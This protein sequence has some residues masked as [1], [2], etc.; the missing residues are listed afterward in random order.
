MTRAYVI[1]EPQ[2]H[3]SKCYGL[4]HFKDKKIAAATLKSLKYNPHATWKISHWTHESPKEKK[5]KL[6]LEKNN[7]LR[8]Q[9][10]QENQIK[11]RQ[12]RENETFARE[13]RKNSK[14]SAEATVVLR[15]G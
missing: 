2:S 1:T 11:A 8:H 4:V 15:N 13:N 9:Q 6:R 10:D 12:D 5:L 7:A 3:V 14:S